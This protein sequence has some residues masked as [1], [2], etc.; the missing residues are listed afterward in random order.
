MEQFAVFTPKGYLKTRPTALAADRAYDARSLRQYLRT[1]GIRPVIPARVYAGKAPRR[2]RPRQL[3]ES[4]YRQRNVVERT[5]GRLKQFRRIATRFEKRRIYF[6]GMLQLACLK[7]YL[8]QFQY[9][10]DTA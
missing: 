4:L 8:K 1:R 7:L 9:L 10:S 6:E 3:D 2:G 5:I